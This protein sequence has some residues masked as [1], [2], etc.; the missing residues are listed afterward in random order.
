MPAGV[1][2]GLIFLLFF[3]WKFPSRTLY[4]V[5]GNA[6]F[7]IEITGEEEGHSNFGFSGGTSLASVPLFETPYRRNT[8]ANI[9]HRDCRKESKPEITKCQARSMNGISSYSFF[10]LERCEED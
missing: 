2:E 5:V 7:G 6:G 1:P 3:Q 4:K 8:R 10:C 9:S